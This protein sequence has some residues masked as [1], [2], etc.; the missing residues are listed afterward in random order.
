MLIVT[1]TPDLPG[2]PL[3]TSV[4]IE[5]GARYHGATRFDTPKVVTID[6]TGDGRVIVTVADPPPTPP[7]VQ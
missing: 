4:V 1:A 5:A 2:E 6:A 7:P 3:G